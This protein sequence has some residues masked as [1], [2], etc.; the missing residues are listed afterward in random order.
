MYRGPL[1][2]AVGT[3]PHQAWSP[4]IAQGQAPAPA[5]ARDTQ[6]LRPG[7]LRREF[8]KFCPANRTT[9]V[10]PDFLER[11]KTNRPGLAPCGWNLPLRPG[12]FRLLQASQR[13]WGPASGEGWGRPANGAGTAPSRPPAHGTGSPKA[14]RLL[15]GPSPSPESRR[16]NA[17]SPNRPPARLPRAYPGPEPAPARRPPP[18]PAAASPRRRPRCDAE[19][20]PRP[21]RRPARPAPAPQPGPRPGPAPPAHGRPA[22]LA[23]M[24]VWAPPAQGAP[25]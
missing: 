17:G 6:P 4:Q 1:H 20:P 12:P 18:A 5:P 7:P 21:P 13:S 10:R 23:A 24:G 22:G 8:K 15:P 11:K 14:Q 2:P 3:F 25:P 9:V 19:P 16:P